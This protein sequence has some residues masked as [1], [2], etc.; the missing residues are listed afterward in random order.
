MFFVLR[1]YFWCFFFNFCFC[2]YCLDVSVWLNFPLIGLCMRYVLS[3][4]LFLFSPLF[5]SFLCYFCVYMSFFLSCSTFA[6]RFVFSL[7]PFLLFFVFFSF[8]SL[9][10]FVFHFFL[11]HFHFPHFP[12]RILHVTNQIGN[13]KTFKR[14]F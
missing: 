2:L 8:L 4:L 7:L 9:F 10:F 6:D 5:I 11:F 12:C 13:R 3:S 14:I 1:L